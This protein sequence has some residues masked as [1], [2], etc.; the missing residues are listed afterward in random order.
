MPAWVGRNCSTHPS[1][2]LKAS[3]SRSLPVASSLAHLVHPRARASLRYHHRNLCTTDLIIY[4]KKYMHQRVRATQTNH[5]NGEARPH[6]RTQ[7]RDAPATHETRSGFSGRETQ[8]DNLPRRRLL[9][10]SALLPRG[11]R[12]SLWAGDAVLVS[13]LSCRKFLD[14]G[15]LLCLWCPFTRT[16]ATRADSPSARLRVLLEHSLGNI[17]R[18]GSLGS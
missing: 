11:A 6:T 8:R 10:V 12:G 13:C 4:H 5:E 9:A 7:L 16:P 3:P 1:R 18:G 17:G 14:T 15:T 2:R